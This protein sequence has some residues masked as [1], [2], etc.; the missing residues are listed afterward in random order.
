MSFN[1]NGPSN[2]PIIQE[3]QNMKN[4][5]GGGNLGYFQRG[6][7]KKDD[8]NLDEEISDFFIK[9]DGENDGKEGEKEK[10]DN[11]F[12]KLKNKIIE[13]FDSKE[14]G[15]APK[16]GDFLSLSKDKDSEQK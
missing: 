6:K 5:G 15:S 8:E 9:E 12:K 13:K 16:Q 3:A 11:L 4:N 1:I 2:K 10:K 7:K 14:G